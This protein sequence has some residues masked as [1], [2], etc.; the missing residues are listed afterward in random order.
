MRISALKTL[1]LAT[2]ASLCL[3]ASGLASAQQAAAPAPR[4]L[5]MQ[6][7]WPASSTLQ[8]NFKLFAERVDKLTGGALKI[9]AMA[10]GQVVPPFEVLDATNKKVIDG[11]HA[12]TYYWQGKDSAATLFASTPAGPFGMDH[13]DFLGWMY[14]GGGMEMYWDWYQNTIKMNVVAF[15]IMPSSPQAFGWFKRPIKDLKDFKG[16]K[17]RETGIVAEIFKRMGMSTVNMPGGEIAAAAQRGV[18]DCAEW[19]GG[20]EDLRLGLPQIYKYHYTPGMHEPSVVGEVIINADVWK[21]LPA[22][23]QEAIRSAATETYVRWWIKWQKQNAEAMEE[24][25]TKF[26]TQILRTPPEILTAFLKAWDEIAVEES[27]K[28]PVFKKVYDSQREYASKVV[29]AKRFMAPPYSFAAN[30]YWPTEAAK[31]AKAAAPAK[32]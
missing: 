29:P 16:L 10:G 25:R 22:Q 17:C 19:V 32:K 14:E 2:A 18:I 23:Q 7:T 9:E 13:M 26:G 21:S 27:A 8:E 3:G 12:V 30:Y 4:V 24:M 1:A 20:V 15:P 5:K 31:P 28:N 11:A 6:S